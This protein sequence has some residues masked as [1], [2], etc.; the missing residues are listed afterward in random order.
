VSVPLDAVRVAVR[1]EWARFRHLLASSDWTVPTRL[2]GWTIGDLATHAVWG[3]SMEA[4]ALHRRRAAG[5]GRADGRTIPAGSD[6]ETILAELDAALGELGRELDQLT[7]DDLTSTAPLPYGD[8]PVVVFSQ[9]LVM[10]AGV[11]TSDLAAAV[12]SPDD[13]APD[14]ASAT[15]ITLGIFLPILAG[16]AEERPAAGTTI[17]V[18]GESVHLAFRC[19]G[20][21][22]ESLPEP[23]AIETD[24]TISADDSTVLLFILG[25]IPD[26]DVRLV[27]SG[28]QAAGR[29]FKRWLPGP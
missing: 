15:G 14:V 23:A 26:T 25:R 17:G 18:R 1:R 2:P 8:V 29:R 27:I 28:D 12:G 9:I 21:G 10:E 3:V 7:E 19:H 24:A 16:S 11:H 13:L 5:G 4:D 22:W 20:D 6:R